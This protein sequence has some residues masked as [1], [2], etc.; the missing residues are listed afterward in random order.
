MSATYIFFSGS[1]KI[2]SFIIGFQPS[3]YDLSKCGYLNIYP[4]GVFNIYPVGFIQHPS[5]MGN[6]VYVQPNLKILHHYFLNYFVFFL[7]FL[8]SPSGNQFTPI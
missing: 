5:P 3:V 8:S 6:W 4:T 2:F 7:V 1:V